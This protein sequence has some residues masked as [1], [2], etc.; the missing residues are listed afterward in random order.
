MKPQLSATPGYYVS[1]QPLHH[2]KMATSCPQTATGPP[3]NTLESLFSSSGDASTY[4][5]LS[6]STV[7]VCSIVAFVW[8]RDDERDRLQLSC[9]C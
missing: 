8:C 3:E 5:V 9:K 6:D 1:L 7:Y 2:D 4:H